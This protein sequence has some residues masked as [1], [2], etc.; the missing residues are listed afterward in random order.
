M[1]EPAED[2]ATVRAREETHLLLLQAE[3]LH[4]LMHRTPELARRLRA[5]GRTRAPHR[6]EQEDEPA[7][8]PGA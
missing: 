1:G 7:G 5:V 6:V 2:T 4:R 8:E 3:D